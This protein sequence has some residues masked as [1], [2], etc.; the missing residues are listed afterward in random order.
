MRYTW[1][2]SETWTHINSRF[3]VRGLIHPITLK[4]RHNGLDSVSNHQPHDCLPK[5]SFKRRSKKTWKLR[6][7]GLCAG[8]SPETGEFP[9]QMASNA[10]NVSIWWRHHEHADLIA[11]SCLFYLISICTLRPFLHLLFDSCTFRRYEYHGAMYIDR[12]INIAMYHTQRW[13][14]ILD[15]VYL[16][17]TGAECGHGMLGYLTFCC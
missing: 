4:W 9:A 13:L 16:A 2:L 10:E 6:V 5:R 3:G 14:N 1:P 12:W 17:A 11:S 15:S 7:T 8:N